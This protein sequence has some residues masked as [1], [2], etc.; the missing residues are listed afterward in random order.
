MAVTEA[1]L[2]WALKM[3]Q[4]ELWV[5]PGFSDTISMCLSGISK[6]LFCT[7]SS[8]TELQSLRAL[9]LMFSCSPLTHVKEQQVPQGWMSL[10]TSPQHSWSRGS[11]KSPWT[12]RLWES[13]WSFQI[14]QPALKKNYTSTLNLESIYLSCGDARK[15]IPKSYGIVLVN[16]SHIFL[17][18][19]SQLQ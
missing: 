5:S 18:L 12:G 2:L 15:K 13:A 7:L 10:A 8:I 16:T 19:L 4:H 14:R 9:V 6:F 17:T 11:S 1:A 3:C